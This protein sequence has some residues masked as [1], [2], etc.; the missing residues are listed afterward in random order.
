MKS[1]TLERKKGRLAWAA[2]LAPAAGPISGPNQQPRARLPNRPVDKSY[3]R[4][5]NDNAAS[6]T[7]ASQTPIS[8]S[9]MPAF[10]TVHSS[11]LRKRNSMGHPICALPTSSV[12]SQV[13]RVG[14]KAVVWTYRRRTSGHLDKTT[15]A[16]A[17]DL[18][19]FKRRRHLRS[20]PTHFVQRVSRQSGRDIQ[21]AE[22][23][24]RKGGQHAGGTRE[25]S[26]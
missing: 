22:L 23:R 10:P 7:L 15:R 5:G 18:D 9:S 8:P 6:V 26:T 12:P 24:R 13:G 20:T 14:P 25:I 17:A 3:C 11:C 19:K 1:G 4:C 21:G 16:R 2:L